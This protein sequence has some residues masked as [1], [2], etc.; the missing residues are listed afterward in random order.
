MANQLQKMI[1]GSTLEVREHVDPIDIEI[2]TLHTCTNELLAQRDKQEPQIL[3]PKGIEAFPS[4][5]LGKIFIFSKTRKAVI[6]PPNLTSPPWTLGRVCSRWRQILWST[7][8]L[9]SY[10]EIRNDPPRREIL[11]IPA[12]IRGVVSHSRGLISLTAPVLT[13]A[14]ALDTILSFPRRFTHLSLKID[15]GAFCAILEL[16]NNSFDHLESLDVLICQSHMKINFPA[17]T[18]TAL[19]A[20]PV[21]ESFSI[22]GA[23]F[24]TCPPYLLLL[25]WVQMTRLQWS[26]KIPPSAV[27]CILAQCASLLVCE[28]YIR[29]E[30][31]QKS[32]G[33][34]HILIPNLHSLSL[35]FGGAGVL[36]WNLFLQPLKL[37]SLKNLRV[38][39]YSSYLPHQALVSLIGRSSCALTELS[40]IDRSRRGYKFGHRDTCDLLQFIPSLEV[41]ETSFIIPDTTFNAISL[42]LLPQLHSLKCGIHP[43]GFHA[44][45]DLME[46]YMQMTPATTYRGVF[47]AN[48]GCYDALGI[49]EVY[50]RFRNVSPKFA[51]DGRDIAVNRTRL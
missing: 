49:D 4:E 8:E 42:G 29:S 18:S 34:G 1:C 43:K 45:L 10:L 9:W 39:T 15:H 47:F 12:A 23:E 3:T 22:R 44:F 46:H 40:L 32:I 24:S 51:K 6:V 17:Y 19:Q 26:I 41:L 11:T 16:P 36:D 33:T 31:P 21:L 37:P 14:S 27:Y 25:P 38:Y 50:K 35:N 48:I 7:P 2:P 5:I 13:T 30:I 20:A 28:I